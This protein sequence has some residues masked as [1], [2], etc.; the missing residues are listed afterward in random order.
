M[1]E[2]TA[3]SWEASYTEIIRIWDI[4]LDHPKVAHAVEVIVKSIQRGKE[5]ISR[6]KLTAVGSRVTQGQ[7][8]S[9]LTINEPGTCYG[10]MNKVVKFKQS[11][12]FAYL[13]LVKIV[14][15]TLSSDLKLPFLKQCLFH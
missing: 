5:C 7:R 1:S 6:K 10:L 4:V 12:C 9:R 15:F 8:M 13:E 14:T 2:D 3:A 11:W